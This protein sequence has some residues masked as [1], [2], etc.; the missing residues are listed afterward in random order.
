MRK[1]II[2]SLIVFCLFLFAV[3]IAKADLIFPGEERKV[4]ESKFVYDGSSALGEYEFTEIFFEKVF[5]SLIIVIVCLSVAALLVA[6][7]RKQKGKVIRQKD[8]KN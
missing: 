4:S 5:I 1:K 6:R 7:T 8:K 3:N 2:I